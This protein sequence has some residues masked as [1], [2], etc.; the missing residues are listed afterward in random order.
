MSLLHCYQEA[1]YKFISSIITITR[2]KAVKGLPV[3]S[4]ELFC[5]TRT[6]LHM[7]FVVEGEYNKTE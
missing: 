5:K 7:N 3:I 6:Y 4:R 2:L 1:R